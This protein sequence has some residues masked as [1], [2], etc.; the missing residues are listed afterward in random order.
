MKQITA[1]NKVICAII[2]LLIIIG[3]VVVIL[4]GFEVDTRNRASQ[5][6]ELNIGK[7]FEIE[8]IKQMTKEVFENTQALIQKIEVFEDSVS[9]TVNE[10]TDEQKSSMVQKVNEKYETEIKDED[11]TIKDV[12]HTS[13]K[14]IVKPYIIPL[15]ISTCIILVYIGIRYYKL[16]MIKSILKF[17]IILV[18]AELALFAVMAI[19]RFPIGRFTLPLTLFV[20]LITALGITTNFENK[21]SEMK[22]EEA[23]E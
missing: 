23:K 18:V 3:T 14:D 11:V 16:G 1:K 15:V 22:L 9:I 4:K 13:L 5:K 19:V 8:D 12:P 21:L 20:Y 7:T 17:G 2:I 10:I 6:I